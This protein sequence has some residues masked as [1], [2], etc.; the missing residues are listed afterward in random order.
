MRKISLLLG[1][2][3]GALGAYVLS[4]KDLRTELQNAKTA[5]HAAKALGKHLQKDSKKLVKEVKQFVESEEVQKKLKEAK[6]YATEQMKE[7]KKS[8]QG[9]VKK[10]QKKVAP[11]VKKNARAA[12]KAVGK[13]S[14][15]AT[16]A[17]DQAIDAV[18]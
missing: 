11:A 1:T 12:K 18:S 14:K 9:V 3:G 8:L 10:G 7:A 6:K 15:A 2:L 16:K 5:D 4:N 13:A 17:L